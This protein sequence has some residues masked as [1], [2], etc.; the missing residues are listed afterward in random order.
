MS[1]SAHV[2]HVLS[3]NPVTGVAAALFAGFLLMALAGPW[4]VP[5]D[6]MQ[7][8]VGPALQAPGSAHWFGTDALGRDIL[9][10]VVVATRLDLGIAFSAVL[11]SLS[12]IHI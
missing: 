12:L 10:R 3:E 1:L 2:R 9:S 4:I 6:P 8:G 5:Y 11:L 7:S